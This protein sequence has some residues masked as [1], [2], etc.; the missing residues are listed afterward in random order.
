MKAYK[1][2]EG[3]SLPQDPKSSLENAA[4][5]GASKIYRVLKGGVQGEGG[6]PGEMWG[7][8]GKIGEH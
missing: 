4:A 1:M 7:F 3:G 2:A 5:N 8:L 6:V